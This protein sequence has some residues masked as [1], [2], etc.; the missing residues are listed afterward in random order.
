MKHLIALLLIA[1]C[2]V[3]AGARGQ[4]DV[5]IS[6]ASCPAPK[7]LSAVH[8]YGAWRAEWEGQ[9][10]RATVQFVRHP[11]NPGSVRGEL[12]RAGVALQVAGDIDNGEFSLEE[13]TDGQRISATWL[14]T[15]V[16]TS[17]GKEIR[18]TWNNALNNTSTPFV[19]RKAPGWQ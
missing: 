15:V 17:C 7:D 18:G 11:D 8:L 9:T 12:T 3:S 4:N 6:P 5:K 19:L 10:P 1:L 16:P 13:S 14:G 2:A